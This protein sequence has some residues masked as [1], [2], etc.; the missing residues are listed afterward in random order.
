[1]CIEKERK[2]E[3]EKRRKLGQIKSMWKR[4]MREK[5]KKVRERRRERK[6]KGEGE[7]EK[8]PTVASRATLNTQRHTT[9]KGPTRKEKAS[10]LS[11]LVVVVFLERGGV[12]LHQ[13]AAAAL[14]HWRVGLEGR[15]RV[16]GQSNLQVVEGDDFQ[17]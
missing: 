6:S 15:E 16:H 2:R 14:H 10:N 12:G 7:R 4:E 9:N 11:G 8:T 1:V 17:S 3:R 13:L 5:K